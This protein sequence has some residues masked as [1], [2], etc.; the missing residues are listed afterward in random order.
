MAPSV[1]IALVT[2]GPEDRHL[3]PAIKK[4]RSEPPNPHFSGL[5]GRVYETDSLTS[6]ADDLRRHPDNRIFVALGFGEPEVYQVLDPD[7]IAARRLS[8]VIRSPSAE[9][10][11]RAYP[12]AAPC[13]STIFVTAE[14]P[15]HAI[16]KAVVRLAA[17]DQVAI[18]ELETESELESYFRLRY[19][20]YREMGYIPASRDY[21]DDDRTTVR[22]D[23]SFTDRMSRPVG[24]FLPGGRMI[25]CAR[26]VNVVGREVP[27]FAKLIRKMIWEK[28]DRIA[29]RNFNYPERIEDPYDILSSFRAYRRHFRELVVNNITNAEVSRVIVAPE[30]RKQGIGEALVDTL[31]AMAEEKRIAVLFLGCLENHRQFY[32]TCGFR[33]LDQLNCESFTDIGVPAIAMQ[34]W[35]SP[36]T[37]REV[38][39]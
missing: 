27:R 20:V 21:P 33:K 12:S 8:V 6:A 13:E 31:V 28:N 30:H 26:L 29:Y 35:L 18:R 1:D 11:T 24:A 36:P 14:D 7:E 15:R 5:V 25:G 38:H 10:R 19:Q 23:V 22:W 2:N 4:W 16:R 39:A 9:R 34:R 3:V 37:P 17:R 32:E